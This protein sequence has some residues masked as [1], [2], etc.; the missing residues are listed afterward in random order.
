MSSKL[1]ATIAGAVAVLSLEASVMQAEAQQRRRS[2]PEVTV[3]RPSWLMTPKAEFPGSRGSMRP[4]M[5]YSPWTTSSDLVA[6]S[7]SMRGPAGPDRFF[8]G[9]GFVVD[10]TRFGFR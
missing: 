3:S 1:I 4:D 8:G 9:P 10:W 2:V 7:T 5:I 6:M